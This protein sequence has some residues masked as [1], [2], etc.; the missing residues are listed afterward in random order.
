MLKLILYDL[1]SASVLIGASS[2]GLAPPLLYLCVS[3]TGCGDER[4]LHRV[5]L[6]EGCLLLAL[7]GLL[8]LLLLS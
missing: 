5:A 3:H 1:I 4:L 7:R 2:L 8:L 6:G